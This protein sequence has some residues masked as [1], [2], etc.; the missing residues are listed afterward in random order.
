MVPAEPSTPP[1]SP[2]D[3]VAWVLA[4]LVALAA[5]ATGWVWLRDR[6]RLG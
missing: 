4:G 2:I 1:V 6:G 5:A 3:V